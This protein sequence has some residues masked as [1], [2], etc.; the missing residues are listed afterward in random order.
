MFLNHFLG[1][2]GGGGVGCCILI[3][4]W[5]ISLKL[6]SNYGRI[7]IYYSVFILIDSSI[8][9]ISL[10]ENLNKSILLLYMRFIK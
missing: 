1:G 10:S 9:K 5:E 4:A 7:T 2:L 8:N 6:I 3:D